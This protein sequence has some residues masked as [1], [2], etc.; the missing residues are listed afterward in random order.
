MAT[1]GSGSISFSDMAAIVYRNSGAQISLGDAEPR[2][3]LGSPS[4]DV[5]MS[6]A[7]SK[8]VAGSASYGP[9]SYTFYVP[10][11]E[12]LTVQVA[13]GGAGGY[14]G[15][16]G[17]IVPCGW[18]WAGRCC[19]SY[20][21]EN[22]GG[23]GGGSSCLDLAAYGGGAGGGAGGNNKNGNTGG[24]GGGGAG[25]PANGDCNNRGGPSGGPGGIV[26][27]TYTKAVDGPGYSQAVGVSVGGGGGGG[28]SCGG[29]PTAYSGGGGGSGWVNISWS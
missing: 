23:D 8:P 12:Y 20:C 6:S 15:S 16:T 29:S 5:S 24:G 13:A 21:N 27:R 9:G 1:P 4:G 22:A 7:Y 17:H 19:E 14:S 10:G 11:Y 28:P 3:L 26:Q 18:Y 2:A 25:G